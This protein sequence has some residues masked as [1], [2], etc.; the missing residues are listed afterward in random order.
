MRY[1]LLGGSGMILAASFFN[2]GVLAPFK[3]SALPS[4]AR[5]TGE[6]CAA[7][8]VGGFGPQLTPHGR[9]FKIDGYADGKPTIP[10]SGM[11]VANFTHT[12][13]DRAEPISGH[14]GPNDNV[15]L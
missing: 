10:F 1:Y 7:C 3:A 9:Q 11:A 15:A 4:Y 14:D 12:D 5:Q 2:V 6:E 13:A 8:H